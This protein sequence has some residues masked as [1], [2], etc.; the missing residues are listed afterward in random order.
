M[1]YRILMHVDIEARDD[2]E[3]VQ[4]ASKLGELLKNPVVR[5]VMSGEGIRLAHSDGRPVV[6]Q[7]QREGT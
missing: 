6:Y 3:S 1:K 4:V 2:Q 7:P 5:M